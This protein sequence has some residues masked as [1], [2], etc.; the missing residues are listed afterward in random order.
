[1]LA[2]ST[3]LRDFADYF[4][5]VPAADR[6]RCRVLGFIPDADK[7]D[8][9]AACDLFAMPSRVD[10]AGIVYLEAWLYDKPVIGANAGGVPEIIADG[11]TGYL[12]PFGDVAQ[13]A[14]HIARL[15]ADPALRARLGAAGHAAVLREHTW[16]AK[17]ARIATIYERLH[18]RDTEITEI[19]AQTL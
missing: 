9:Y 10:T 12:V 4:S 17:I 6:D 5:T 18:H 3:T 2:G 1:V 16:D 11:A 19:S 8:A 14:D 7:R 15:L 13:L